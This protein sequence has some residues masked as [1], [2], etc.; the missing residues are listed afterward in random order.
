[1]KIWGPVALSLALF[2]LPAWGAPA[3]CPG[4]CNEDGVVRIDELVRMAKGARL[5][6]LIPEREFCQ[7]DPCFDADL[8]GDD[9]VTV[10]ELIHAIN[11]VVQAVAHA[12]SGCP[13]SNDA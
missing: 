2:V 9:V 4:D 3:E 8:D 6:C 13:M 5:V 12:L 11:L 10:N 1:M 7:P